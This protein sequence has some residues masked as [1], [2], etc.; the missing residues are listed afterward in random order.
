MTSPD[1]S[2]Y[3]F[4]R[5]FGPQCFLATFGQVFTP[6]V[7]LNLFHDV[8][9]VFGFFPGFVCL[10]CSGDWLGVLVFLLVLPSSFSCVACLVHV[11]ILIMMMM[12][13]MM[14]SWWLWL[15]QSLFLFLVLSCYR[16]CCYGCG[17]C[18]CG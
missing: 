14:I 17:C 1:F 3:Q 6:H 13:M 18:C 12:M 8:V 7:A 11:V 15:L 10:Y 5:F 16:G 2:I 4:R 9:I